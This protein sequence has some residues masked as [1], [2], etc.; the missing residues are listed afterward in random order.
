MKTE[1]FIKYFLG[2]LTRLL[3]DFHKLRVTVLVLY[4]IIKCTITSS[5]AIPL[6]VGL[7][8]CDVVPETYKS[9]I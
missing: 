5:A 6:S 2:L 3:H 1:N 9:L 8:L 7:Y 4:V